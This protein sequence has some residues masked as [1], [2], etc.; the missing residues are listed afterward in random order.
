[1]DLIQLLILHG[2]VYLTGASVRCEC[3]NKHQENI[4][5][6]KIDGATCSNSVSHCK[7]NS[8]HNCWVRVVARENTLCDRVMVPW[9]LPLKIRISLR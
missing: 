2:S 7:L 9:S 4:V 3:K 8:Q 1:M 5:C 6:F